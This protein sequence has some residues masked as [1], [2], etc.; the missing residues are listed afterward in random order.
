M[1][2][3]SS[4]IIVLLST[5]FIMLT[6]RD[7][8]R[9]AATLSPDNDND[10]DVEH[11]H[12][13]GFDSNKFDD[14]FSDKDT[15]ND[16]DLDAES[17]PSYDQVKTIPS[18]KIMKTLNQQT[19]KFLFC[20]SCGYRNM[21]EQYSQLI[22]TRFPE[23]KIIGENYPPAQYKV[24]LTQFLSTFKLL[25]I[26]AILFGQNPFAYFNMATPA[27]FTW[28]IE[29]KLYAC[30]MIF[31]ISNTVESSLISTGAFEIYLNDNQIWSK[32]QSDRMPHEKEIMQILDMNFNFESQKKAAFGAD[33]TNF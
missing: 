26:G 15:K 20:Y 11:N 32:L 22:Q 14:D 5:L 3:K 24:Y 23:I 28:A 16:G 8:V 19:L 2:N 4:L 7:L 12:D 30:M 25:L 29:N 6:F 13:D 9:Q 17:E 1:V 18:L 21:F 33:S 31:F 10:D 27:F